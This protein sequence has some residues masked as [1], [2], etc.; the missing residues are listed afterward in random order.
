MSHE[1]PVD[2]PADLKDAYEF[3]CAACGH[4]Q[5]AAPSIMMTAF[6][7]NSGAGNCLECKVHLHL[8][9]AP[10]NTKMVSEIWS[11]WAAKEKEALSNDSH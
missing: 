11:E 1:M 2:K 7:L 8:E 4:N 10:D 6:G 3:D 5:M 9:I